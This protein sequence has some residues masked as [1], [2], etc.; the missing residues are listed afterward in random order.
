[1]EAEGGGVRGTIAEAAELG[2]SIV[3]GVPA[4]NLDQWR[5]FAGDLSDE[6]ESAPIEVKT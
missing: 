1:M 3:V 6:C 5:N 4:R 2:I